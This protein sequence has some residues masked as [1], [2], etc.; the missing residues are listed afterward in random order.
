MALPFSIEI[1]L[2]I[3]AMDQSLQH[4]KIPEIF[5]RYLNEWGES[6]IYDSPPQFKHTNFQ[7]IPCH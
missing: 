5:I 6:P 4:A 7:S 2:P 1:E 3:S